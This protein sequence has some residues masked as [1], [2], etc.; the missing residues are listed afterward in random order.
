MPLFP[1]IMRFGIA[2]Q[3]GLVFEEFW[4]HLGRIAFSFVSSLVYSSGATLRYSVSV[5]DSTICLTLGLLLVVLCSLHLVG[6]SC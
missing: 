3:A 5:L 4:P 6:W 1:D 2:H